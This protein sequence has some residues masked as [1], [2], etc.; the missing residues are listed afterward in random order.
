[1]ATPIVPLKDENNEINKEALVNYQ[2]FLIDAAKIFNSHNMD[3]IQETEENKKTFSS[4]YALVKHEEAE[5]G[6]YSQILFVRIYACVDKL[7]SRKDI[8]N[9]LSQKAEELK[10][11]ADKFDQSWRLDEF[12]VNDK[13]FSTY[14]EALGYI[15]TH[16][17]L[18]K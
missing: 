16:L 3:V 9:V 8:I 15:D 10:A 12:L 4:Y 11:P 13:H 1:M 18:Y 7:E 2:E 5:S 17:T 6:N 14:E